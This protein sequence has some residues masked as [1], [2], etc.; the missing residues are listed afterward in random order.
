MHGHGRMGV[1]EPVFPE[2]DEYPSYRVPRPIV[3]P[4]AEPRAIVKLERYVREA[5]RA[6]G[7]QMIA[8]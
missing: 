6:T 1:V 8:H 5:L 7:T 3:L 2:E 4:R